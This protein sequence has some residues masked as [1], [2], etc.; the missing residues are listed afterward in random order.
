MSTMTFWWIVFIALFIVVY[1][2]DLYVTDHRKG[3]I[4]VK[5][6]LRWTAAWIGIS[7]VFGLLL[8]FFFPQN[9]DSAADTSKIMGIKFIAGYLTEKSLS[10]DNLFVFIFIF[11]AM[12]IT[13]KNQ[14][15][16]LKMGIMIS[17]V[18]RI[19]FILVGMTLVERFHWIIYVFGV[20][21]IYT[22]CKMAFSKEDGNVDPKSNVL[23]KAASKLFPVDPDAHSPS[24]FTRINGKIHI[25]VMFLTLLAIGST[26]ILFAV[27][28]IP[29]I[30]GVINEGTSGVLTVGE[31]NFLAV[32]SNVFAVM[33]MV[34][35]FFALKGIMGMFRFL[36]HGV[37]FILLFIGLKMLLGYFHPVEAFFSAHSWMSLA[38][39]LLTLVVSIAL[40]KVI[41]E[42]EKRK[43]E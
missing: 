23:Y 28:S 22:A 20:I 18:L 17:I 6:A 3:T 4:S 39:I 35:L 36:K 32:S 31:E 34:A 26:D 12:G 8:Y 2:I 37:S 33:G 43:N 30:I 24:F 11:S 38:V 10:V 21:I 19:L 14:P 1:V 27:D 16:L 13:D 40:S 25:T 41:P 7:F 9:P 5:T 42:E 15:R 29:A